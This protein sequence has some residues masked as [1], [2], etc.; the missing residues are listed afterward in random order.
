MSASRRA[1][2]AVLGTAFTDAAARRTAFWTQILAMV[3]NDVAWVL[4]W[5]IFFHRVQSV[6]GWDAHQVLLLFAVLTTS[7]G[8]V[9][10]L[11]SNCRRI[12]AAVQSGALDEVLSL[13]IYAEMTD[14]MVDRVATE[15][16]AFMKK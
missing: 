6:R 12:P 3:V 16:R 10:G 1:T 14:A 2:T 9:L 4:F 7:A 11:L 8:L 5:L 15:V 13:P